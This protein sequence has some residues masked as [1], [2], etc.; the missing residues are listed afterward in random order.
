MTFAE[1][2]TAVLLERIHFR[3]TNSIVGRT[4]QTARA[5][6]WRQLALPTVLYALARKTV[7]ELPSAI[8]MRSVAEGIASTDAIATRD[9]LVLATAFLLRFVI[10]YPAWAVLV[11]FE[12]RRTSRW[13]D[14]GR[15]KSHSYIYVLK[16][17]Y[18]KV[19]LRLC[20]LH[21]QAAGIMIGIDTVTHT[22]ANF[23]LH[24]PPSPS[25]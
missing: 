1:L 16:R 25:L 5:Y 12:T 8:R 17:C 13:T 9:I 6:H 22:V 19:L 4:S 18:Q 11:A 3:W 14:T 24:T 23:L 15:E 20:G 10:L 7:T 2:A 21:L